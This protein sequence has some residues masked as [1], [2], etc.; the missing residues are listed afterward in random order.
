MRLVTYNTAS[1]SGPRIGAMT[2]SGLVDL[3]NGLGITSV[4]QLLNDGLVAKAES[5][6]ESGD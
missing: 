2:E 5:L 6:A 1:H 3:S 4:R